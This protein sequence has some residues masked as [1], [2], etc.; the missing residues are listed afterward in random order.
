MKTYHHT[1][2]KILVFSVFAIFTSCTTKEIIEEDSLSKKINESKKIEENPDDVILSELFR[3]SYLYY[4]KIRNENGLYRDH[5]KIFT[6]KQPSAGSIANQGMGLVGLCIANEMNWESDAEAMAL[7]TL[8]AVA[9]LTSGIDI[10]RNAKGCFVHFFDIEDGHVNNVT[11]YSPIDTDIMLLGAMFTKEYF[12]DNTEIASIVNNLVATVD[13]SAF[14][15]DVNIGQIALKVDED[16]EQAGNYWALPY[17]EYMIVAWM[18]YNQAETD[19][20]P[21]VQLWNLHYASPSTLSKATYIDDYGNSYPV[22]SVNTTRFT[23]MFTFIFNYALVH[24]FSD[25][26][27]YMDAMFNAAMA[28]KAWWNDCDVDVEKQSYEWGTGAGSAFKD[29]DHTRRAYSADRIYMR[30]AN[31]NK[32]NKQFIVSPHI[33]AGFSPVKP[34]EVRD[35]L[36]AMYKDARGMARY[37]IEPGKEVLWRYSYLDKDWRATTIEGIDYSC[38]LLGMASLPQFLG[39]NFFNVYNDVFKDPG[40]GLE[41]Y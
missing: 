4:Q 23:S 18:A 10:P 40:L 9:G 21:A 12:S 39:T 24:H 19:D 1:L 26:P 35:D 25:S 30:G 16:G 29:D 27:D 13:Q 11:E 28:D 14:I 32:Y 36:L 33:V 20:D 38:M 22:L 6:E 31:Y 5:L 8:K 3:N 41:E 17:N 37:E 15:G 7:Q 2:A 34:V